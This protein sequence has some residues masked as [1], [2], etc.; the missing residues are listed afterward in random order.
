MCRHVYDDLSEWISEVGDPAA[1]E[2]VCV[3]VIWK[4]Q[5]RV[6]GPAAHVNFATREARQVEG[7]VFERKLVERAMFPKNRRTMAHGRIVRN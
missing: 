6:I 1:A 3:R 5:G 2:S 7:V 4:A